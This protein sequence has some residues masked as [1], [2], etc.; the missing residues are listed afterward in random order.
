MIQKEREEEQQFYQIQELMKLIQ[1]ETTIVFL[2]DMKRI[3]YIE[4]LD[5]LSVRVKGKSL[6]LNEFNEQ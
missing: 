5:E 4:T 3:R 1:Q 6:R 2:F